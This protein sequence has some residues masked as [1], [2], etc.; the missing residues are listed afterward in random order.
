MLQGVCIDQGQSAV[1]LKGTSYYLFP[2]GSSHFYVSKFPN[3]N[4]HKGCFQA[5]YFQIIEKELWPEEPEVRSV[6]LDPEKVYK[7]KLIWRKPGYETTL[8]KQYNLKPLKTHA[9]FFRDSECNELAGCFPLHWFTGF[10]ELILEK[11]DQEIPD[12]VIDFEED[13]Q[14]IDVLEQDIANYVQLSLFD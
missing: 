9:F 13:D 14:Y 10:E 1:L 12:F 4:T 5:K 3:R 7:A 6:S 8:L 2:N 11:I